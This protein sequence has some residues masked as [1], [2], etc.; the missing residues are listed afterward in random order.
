[1]TLVEAIISGAVQGITEFLPVS[2]SGHLVLLHRYFDLSEPGIFFDI[3]LHVGTL[4]AVLLYF[5]REILSIIRERK[6]FWVLC[7]AVGTIPAVVAAFFFEGMISSF[8]MDPKKVAFMLIVTGLVLFAGQFGLWAE[9]SEKRDLTVLDSLL[10]GIAQAF[11]LL[12]GISRSGATISTGL[13]RGMKA[14][15]AFSF[16][17]L[18]AIP[19]IIGAVL[20]KGMKKIA[21]GAALVDDPV[22]YIAGMITAFVVGLMCLPLLLKVVRTK[23]L[24]IFGIYCLVLGIGAIFF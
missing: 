10:I 9:R 3:C 5:S 14:E 4:A 15:T 11:A 22:N 7:I 20:Y 21:E 18:L 19:A 24:Y 23:R 6:T 8:F 17:F 1:M 13:V 2:S 16:S 12:P